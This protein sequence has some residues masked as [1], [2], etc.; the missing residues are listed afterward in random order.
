MVP[1]MGSQDQPNRHW[2]GTPQS[3]D[4]RVGRAWRSGLHR[5]RQPPGVAIA[6]HLAS[7]VTTA[8]YDICSN[9]ICVQ[10]LLGE[11]CERVIQLPDASGVLKNSK[12]RTADGFSREPRSA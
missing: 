5:D 12:N 9:R 3:P 8:H 2:H 6:H 7:E 4:L 11:G 1:Q 10:T